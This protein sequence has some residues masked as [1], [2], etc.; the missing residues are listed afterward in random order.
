LRLPFRH[1]GTSQKAS[2]NPSGN[3]PERNNRSSGLTAGRPFNDYIE[4]SEHPL[5]RFL[6]G[7][8]TR[9]LESE[10]D[11]SQAV[12]NFSATGGFPALVSGTE[13][14]DLTPPDAKLPE[15]PF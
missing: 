6:S 9:A 12:R 5:K 10:L 15:C 3:L 2:T 1:I 8:C 4:K 7:A 13:E 14:A 11:L